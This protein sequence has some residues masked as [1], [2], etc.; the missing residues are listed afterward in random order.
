VSL[1]GRAQTERGQDP[2]IFFEMFRRLLLQFDPDDLGFL[3]VK[4][5]PRERTPLPPVSASSQ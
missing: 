2:V 4:V 5:E 1:A 3:D